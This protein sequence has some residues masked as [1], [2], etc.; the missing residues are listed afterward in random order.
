[1]NVKQSY[2]DFLQEQ[3]AKEKIQAV[4]RK[5]IDEWK[6]QPAYAYH[7][8]DNDPGDYSGHCW[9]I[10]D[11]T[12]GD[13]AKNDIEVLKAYTGDSEAT[14]A[15]GCGLR[16]LRV[17]DRITSN[18]DDCLSELKGQFITKNADALFEEYDIE[19][20]DSWTEDDIFL[21]LDEAMIN[22]FSAS[23]HYEWMQQEFPEYENDGFEDWH[24]DY[25][26]NVRE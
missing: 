1:M 20:D 21:T 22:E 10:H 5:G 7:P 4:I 14:Y 16:W 12:I 8:D 6:R 11:K 24:T 2:F 26:F 17:A 15:S 9:S 25:L 18:I 3:G 19:H 13:I 23:L